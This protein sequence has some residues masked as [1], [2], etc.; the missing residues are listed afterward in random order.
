MTKHARRA[1]D[2]ETCHHPNACASHALRQTLAATLGVHHISYSSQHQKSF[3][4][5]FLL[6]LPSSNRLRQ[7]VLMT[8]CKCYPSTRT[9]SPWPTRGNLAWLSLGTQ[10][11][12][13]L[14]NEEKILEQNGTTRFSGG[15]TQKL[16]R[17]SASNN[18]LQR[19]WWE[20]FILRK[21]CLA[22]SCISHCTQPFYRFGYILFP[23]G[24]FM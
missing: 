16:C 6:L 11:T 20:I 24:S 2:L 19:L 21:F 8:L 12:R 22:M 10:W 7:Q 17:D 13:N 18:N 14:A 5:S 4:P 3:I 1:K 23:E 15:T 9:R